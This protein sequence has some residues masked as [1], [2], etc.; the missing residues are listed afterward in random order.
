MLYST[1]H[2]RWLRILIAILGELFVAISLKLFIVPMNLY[3]GNIM[4]ACQLANTLL[5]RAGLIGSGH[6]VAGILFFLINAPIL[7]LAFR[8][9][10]QNLAFK[11]ILCTTFY[12]LFYSLIPSPAAPLVTD[13]WTACLLGGCLSGIGYGVILTCGASG[14]GLDVVG[15]YLNKHGIHLSIGRVSLVFN[16][17]LYAICLVLFHPEIV[18]YSVI[19]NF[20]TSAM[21]DRMHQ[22]NINVQ[23][24]IFTRTGGEAIGSFV[25]ERL[26]RSVTYLDGI[27]GYTGGS[28]QLLCVY[29]SKYEV[30]ELLRVVSEIDPQAFFTVQEG[31]R[32]YGNFKRNLT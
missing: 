4:G 20:F 8:S 7:L 10:G 19:F 32:I 27:G 15:L 25:I 22:Q 29:L 5:N 24:L 6:D 31:V 1:L 9:L 2:N 12:S 3:A 17:F 16:I 26:N 21:Q 30:E 13:Y 18:I 11:T 23:A 28:V 14:G